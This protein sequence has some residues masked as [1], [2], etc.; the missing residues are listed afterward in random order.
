MPRYNPFS[1]WSGTDTEKHYD[2]DCG[3][4][5]LQVSNLLDR[6]KSYDI[7]SLN[8][9]IQSLSN[10]CKGE[11]LSSLFFNIDG[12]KTNFNHF[13][14]LLKSISHNFKV[15]GLAETNVSP[16]SSGPFNVPDY[17]SHY[18]N[19]REGKST[20]T[21]VALYIHNSLNT[22]IV[23]EISECGPDI[24]SL[25]IKTTN[26]DRPYYY[27]VVYRPNDG[28]KLLFYEKLQKIFDHLP[29]KGVYIMGD[30]NIN[31]LNKKVDN[32]YEETIYSSGYTPLISTITHTKSGCS[33]SCIDNIL[34]NEAGSTLIS[35][36]ISDNISHHFPIFQLT[37]MFSP[38]NFSNQQKHKQEYE[39]SKKN[40]DAF[41]TDLKQNI[42]CIIPSTNFEEFTDFFNKTLDKNCKLET[43]KIT[44]RTP[45][46]NPW[47]TDGLIESIHKKHKM[48]EE[49]V[50]TISHKQPSGDPKLREKFK[51][52][53]R[54]L[55]SLINASKSSFSQNK[56]IECK[57]DR[58]KTWK[59]INE[60]RGSTKNNLKPCFV[61]DNKRITNRRTIA[62]KFNEYF[63]SIATKL[64]EGIL[65]TK[66]PD[67]SIQSFTSYLGNSNKKSF[68][69]FDCDTQEI[70]KIISELQNGKSSDIPV[71]VIKK[72][73]DII[74]PTL[75]NYFNLLMQAGIFPD[76]C[77]IGKITPIFKKGDT[78]LLENYR[79]ISTLPIFSK[80]FEKVIYSRLYSFFTSQH[81]LYDKQFGFR[82]SHTTSHAINHSVAH[83]HKEISKN[84][85]VLGI[86]ID[87]SKAFDTIDHDKLLYK[88]NHYGV[89]GTANK[90]IKS[91]LENRKQYVNCLNEDS[92]KMD[93]L[94]GVPQ[95]SVLG[96]LLFLIYI[97]D[98][99]NC[100]KLGEFVL[101]ADDTNIFVSGDTLSEA[102][103]I[104]NNVLSTISHYMTLNKLHINMTKCCYMIFKP[105]TKQKH[106][107]SDVDDN[108]IL[109]IND[110]PIKLVSS[111]KF[112]GVTIDD[113][114][115]WDKHVTDLKRKLYYSL[116]TLSSIKNLVPK[117]LIKDLYFT[118]FESHISYCISV[119][120]GANKRKIQ[121]IHIIQKKAIRVLFG[122]V[123][124]F[125]DKFKTCCRVRPIDQQILDSKFYEKEHTKP[126]FKQYNILTVQNL[127]IY[128]SFMETFK[129]LKFRTP[130]AL[131][132]HFQISRRKYLTYTKLIPPSPSSTF[133]YSAS[134]L[135]NIIR[136]K[137]NITDLSVG[138]SSIKNSLKI[139]LHD[140]Q[141]ANSTIEWL[142]D[143]DYDP[144]RMLFNRQN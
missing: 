43:P 86:F 45:Q 93:I 119:Y 144:S 67:Q 19:T 88:L 11:L 44:K 36:T 109:M 132:D 104:A 24:E 65:D 33:S 136:P 90:L 126:L 52:Y 62:L 27:G 30:Y 42:S 39:F 37:Q 108:P 131:L 70:S 100:S 125:K 91:Y 143:Y 40:T 140:N 50:K 72:A 53:S 68:A 116:S 3:D 23:D 26:T 1:S 29:K 127:F 89:R 87:L 78:E 94:F 76:I 18:Q 130:L 133:I 112:L 5:V 110:I 95:G 85:Y 34:T 15:I 83:I 64:N 79:P 103:L 81:L 25:I 7:K 49:W 51:S 61:I 123:E 63:I 74:S 2:S 115:S 77:K 6:C 107:E 69:L 82:K 106:Q 28:N 35:G 54:T 13:L 97:N 114:L 105:K 84:K 66:L 22:T 111:T 55:K 20:G 124:A 122:D 113:E 71:K 32:S 102:T 21:G 9:T 98:I 141:H 41:L 92:S 17:T 80:I 118:L 128:H 101:F 16:Y 38:K 99:V 12:N 8:S 73:S 129:I 138:L 4:D 31:L 137:L 96:P 134:V 121:T 47:I 14:V 59:L 58:K 139:A 60:L 57:E 135:W 56:F 46:N 10:D 120:G 117:E 75:S 48:K 142:D